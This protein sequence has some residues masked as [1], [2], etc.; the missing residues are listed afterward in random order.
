M[1]IVKIGRIVRLKN[2]N[3]SFDVILQTH[4]TE[5][6][7]TTLLHGLLQD[8][9]DKDELTL[10]HKDDMFIITFSK[11][12]KPDFSHKGKPQEMALFINY[13][14]ISIED[15]GEPICIETNSLRIPDTITR[16]EDLI[17]YFC[18]QNIICH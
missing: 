7:D 16:L 6:E 2:I 10:N 14:K 8:F 1:N 18:E 11:V 5:E 13:R 3:E 12:I 9:G 4:K 15:N 17:I